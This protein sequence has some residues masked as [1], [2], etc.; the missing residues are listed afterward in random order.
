MGKYVTREER[1]RRLGEILL[2]GVYL[3]VE[4]TD[5][6]DPTKSESHTASVDASSLP[7]EPSRRQA[8][9]H[10][11]SAVESPYN[12]RCPAAGPLQSEV[13][14]QLPAGTRSHSPAG[15]SNDSVPLPQPVAP[16]RPRSA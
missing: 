6:P 12:G 8:T 4:T 10:R 2:K 14:S 16:A 3:W 9:I 5:N 7:A 1:L 13:A 15:T 11:P